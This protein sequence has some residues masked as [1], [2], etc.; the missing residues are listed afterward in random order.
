MLQSCIYLFVIYFFW[1]L[2]FILES[3]IR[4]LAVFVC[5]YLIVRHEKADWKLWTYERGLIDYNFHSR[6]IWL[7]HFI[8]EPSVSISLGLSVEADQISQRRLFKSLLAWEWRP[9]CQHSRN[10]AFSILDVCIHLNCCFQYSMYS[11]QLCPVS[12]AQGTTALCS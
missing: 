3:F 7:I 4:C 1:S 2:S 12:P 6:V 11:T 10:Q 5:S 9:G 8:E